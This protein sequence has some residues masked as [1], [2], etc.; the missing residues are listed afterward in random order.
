MAT[1]TFSGPI[2]SN[3]AFWANPI[4]FADLPSAASANEGYIYYVSDAL[5]ASETA[6]NGTGNLVFSDGSNWIRVDTGA[7]AGA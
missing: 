3:A 5:K 4:A 1:T 7:T 2:K 6:G